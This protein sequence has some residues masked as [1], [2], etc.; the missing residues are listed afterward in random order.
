MLKYVKFCFPLALWLCV[1]DKSRLVETKL[2]YAQPFDQ[3]LIRPCGF[4]YSCMNQSC[5]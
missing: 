1:V 5:G 4:R 3:K 2:V